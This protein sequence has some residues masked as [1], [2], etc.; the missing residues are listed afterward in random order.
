MPIDRSYL[1]A[2][3]WRA[4]WWK[5]LPRMSFLLTCRKQDLRIGLG[6]L[7]VTQRARGMLSGSGT[8]PLL[9]GKCSVGSKG[10]WNGVFPSWSSWQWDGSP[11]L[12]GISTNSGSCTCRES[13]GGSVK[14]TFI[15]VVF[16]HMMLPPHIPL[17][18]S[19]AMQ[20]FPFSLWIMEELL[21]QPCLLSRTCQFYPQNIYPQTTPAASEQEHSPREGPG[22][23]VCWDVFILQNLLKSNFFLSI[24]GQK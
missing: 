14:D 9:G 18:L 23:R 22:W 13:L 11:C 1:G 6:T 21:P 16:S 20:E 12:S 17:V 4:G 8:Q 7:R 24:Q 5:L 2:C 19:W 3:C 15:S 10:A